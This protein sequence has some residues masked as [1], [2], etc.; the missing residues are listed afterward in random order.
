MHEAA[1]NYDEYRRRRPPRDA[2]QQVEKDV[3]RTH[4][5]RES[6]SDALRRVLLAHAARNTKVGYTQGLNHVAAVLLAERP[7]SATE[8]EVFWMLCAIT[9]RLLPEYYVPS[10]VGVVPLAG[11]NGQRAAEEPLLC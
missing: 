5:S 7:P 8:A 6:E 1:E 2:A 10:L 3:H 4:S 9:E 11:S